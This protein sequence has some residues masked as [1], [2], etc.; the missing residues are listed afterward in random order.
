MGSATA[1]CDCNTYDSTVCYVVPAD[2][3]AGCR[4]TIQGSGWT[5]ERYACSDMAVIHGYTLQ[6]ITR[7]FE[8]CS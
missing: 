2:V 7:R 8:V 1:G 4:T 6:V 3:T 5:R